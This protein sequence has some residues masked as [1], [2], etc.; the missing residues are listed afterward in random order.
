MV[1]VPLKMISELLWS[2]TPSLV[3]FPNMITLPDRLLAVSK[4]VAVMAILLKLVM[5][6][7]D[8]VPVPLKFTVLEELKGVAWVLLLIQLPLIV[9]A[10]APAFSWA[11][12]DN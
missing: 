3:Q 12:E 2:K 5:P 6:V 10:K 9:M 1:V 8:I 7:P 11:P 4:P